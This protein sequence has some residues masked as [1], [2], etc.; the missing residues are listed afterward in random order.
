MIQTAT[1]STSQAVR[2]PWSAMKPSMIRG[3][4]EM[5]IAPTA[6]TIP[7][8]VPRRRTNHN[9]A[10]V[11]AVRLS[12]PWPAMRMPTKPA[13]SPTMPLTV[14]KAIRAPPNTAPMTA[15]V[16][17]MPKRSSARPTQGIASAPVSV[18]IRYAVE[19]ADRET[20]SSAM[21]GSMNTE[22]PAV[23]PGPVAARAMVE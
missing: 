17:R 12:A 11:V 22:T 16:R 14:D 13:V 9:A 5:P 6:L 19:M 3:V 23:W 8:A 18:P 2:Q 1:P 20:F 10:A 4:I 7:V 21:T 15:I